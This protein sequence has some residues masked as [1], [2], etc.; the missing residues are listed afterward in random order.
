MNYYKNCLVCKS[1]FETTDS[2]AILCGRA[3]CR[4]SYNALLPPVEYEL[5]KN[6]SF[7]CIVCGASFETFKSNKRVCSQ[8]C[9]KVYNR[10][11]TREFMRIMRAGWKRVCIDCKQEYIT[12]NSKDLLCFKCQLGRFEKAKEVAKSVCQG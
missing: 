1:P 12:Y 4:Q 8:E 6:Y 3:E 10:N 2:K 9:R 11:K 5:Q 7:K